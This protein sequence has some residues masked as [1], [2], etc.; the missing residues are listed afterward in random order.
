MV[1]LTERRRSR[2]GGWREG[3]LTEGVVIYYAAL[4]MNVGEWHRVFETRE[5]FCRVYAEIDSWSIFTVTGNSVL[6]GKRKESRTSGRG[7]DEVLSIIMNTIL[8]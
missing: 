6:V 2:R 8:E 3:W 4:R 5:L 1:Q 7:I